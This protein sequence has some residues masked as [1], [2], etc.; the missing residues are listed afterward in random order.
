LNPNGLSSS[1]LDLKRRIVTVRVRERESIGN[2]E[3]SNFGYGGWE[4]G[5][6]GPILR[7]SIINEEKTTAKR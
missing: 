1:L 7:N 4:M 2:R 3:I 5:K 6:V